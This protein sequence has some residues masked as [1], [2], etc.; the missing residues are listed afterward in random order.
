MKAMA[1]YAI[2]KHL[3]TVNRHRF[4]VFLYCTRCGLFWR[5]LVH[6][7]SKYSPSEFFISARNYT[8]TKSPIANERK[9]EHGYSKV[10]I[11]HTRKNKHHF[12]YWVDVTTGDILLAPMPFVYALESCC[13]M[14]AASKVYNGKK[15]NRSLP[16]AFFTL[17]SPRSLMHPATKEFIRTV[18]TRYENSGFQGIHRR[19]MEKL[20]FS[21]LAK[22][23][24]TIFIPVYSRDHPNEKN[25][26]FPQGNPQEK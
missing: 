12:E 6:D 9:E 2:F 16:L 5:G 18:L 19:E 8:G 10:F 24:P 25:P 26:F 15:F 23:P 14:I 1:K 21:I 22:Y 17:S 11:H 20:Y 4:L 7:L 13:D 3:H